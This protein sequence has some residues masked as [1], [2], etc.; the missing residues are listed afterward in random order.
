NQ[1]FTK[2]FG[3]GYNNSWGTNYYYYYFHYS[4][5]IF[6]IDGGISGADWCA[7]SSVYKSGLGLT[8]L[9][10]GPCFEGVSHSHLVAYRKGNDTIGVFTPDSIL[11]LGITEPGDLSKI[12]VFPNPTTGKLKVQ[13]AQCRIESLDLYNLLGE[14]V[15]T[16][17]SR[18]ELDIAELPSGIY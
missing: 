9:V 17:Q 11:L 5:D 8:D 13:N 18:K 15:M 14:K 12:Q 10:Y 6:F 4:S 16:F 2:S 7:Y 1:R 3:I